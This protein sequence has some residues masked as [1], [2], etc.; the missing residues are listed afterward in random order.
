MASVMGGSLR[1]HTQHGVRLVEMARGI[2]VLFYYLPSRLAWKLAS[3]DICI[4]N[5]YIRYKDPWLP[6]FEC[7]HWMCALLQK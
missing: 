5:T 3:M 2:F 1:E 4:W 6:F 7:D